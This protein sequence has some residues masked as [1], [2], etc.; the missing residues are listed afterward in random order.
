MQLLSPVSFCTPVKVVK[1]LRHN[2]N[3][4]L[5]IRQPEPTSSS[6]PLLVLPGDVLLLVQ[7]CDLRSLL[8][9]VMDDLATQ[10]FSLPFPA[11]HPAPL[12]SIQQSFLKFR[13]VET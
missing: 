9:G 12:Y 4:P 5:Q 11:P 8:L 6:E 3:H 13:L 10:D 7:L 2:S 1:K